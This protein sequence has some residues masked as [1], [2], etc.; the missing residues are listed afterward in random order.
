MSQLPVRPPLVG[1]SAEQARLDDL[2]ADA[3][4]GRSRALV[5][6]GEAGIG[7][8]TLLGHLAA[9][10]DGFR[11]LRATGVQ[12]EAEIPFAGLQVLLAP[13]ADRVDGLPPAQAGALRA[14]L[15][16]SAEPGD[17]LLVRA[18]TLTLMSE[19]AEDRP[20]LC[21]LDDAHLIDQASAAALLFAVR[22]MHDD[23][24][25]VVLAAGTAIDRSP[26]RGS[27]ASPFRDW[28]GPAQSIF[29]AR[30]ERSPRPSSIG[31]CRTPAAIPS[32]CSNSPPNRRTA[33][34]AIPTR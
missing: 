4:A 25:G 3:A 34:P 22:R 14:A 10:A 24:V 20:L 16:A 23:P 5:L 29:W 33:S 6:R 8:T 7:K 27:R 26:P 12:S 31:S 18:A 1:R 9:T 13:V 30:S 21:L 11:V 19:L 28:T 32:P 15:G 17:A 2:L